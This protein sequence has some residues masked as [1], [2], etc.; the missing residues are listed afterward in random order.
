MTTTTKEDE[1][2][3]EKV[4]Q[5]CR[6]KSN[7]YHSKFP[8]I[9]SLSSNDLI[10]QQSQRIDENSKIL[11]VDV[12]TQAERNISIIPNSISLS[13]F[14]NIMKGYNPTTESS[15]LLPFASVVTYCTV[16]YRSGIEARRL[17]DLYSLPRVQNLDGI[18]SYTH[19]CGSKKGMPALGNNLV[20]SLIHPETKE[21]TNQVHIFGS[22]WNY[23]HSS[24][25]IKFFNRWYLAWMSLQVGFLV[26][27]RKIQGWKK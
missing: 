22:S 19:A 4:L 3:D 2:N 8:D 24:Y 7:F 15:S 14:H 25:E 27:V 17:R 23:V 21:A 26:L 10:R 6:S 11:L 20:A 13:E 18:I 5:E 9:P 1:N 16:G 12:R